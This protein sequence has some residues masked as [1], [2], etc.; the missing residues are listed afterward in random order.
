MSLLTNIV[1]YYKFDADNSNDALGTNNGTDTSMSY[2]TGKINDGAIFNG[3]TGKIDIGTNASLHPTTYTMT[4]W[5]KAGGSGTRPI[6]SL[7]GESS[8]CMR[9]DTGNTI[10][11]THVDVVNIGTSTG[12]VTNGTFAFICATY[13]S[14]TG[15]WQIYINGSL[16]NSGTNSQT[17]SFTHNGLIGEDGTVTH[18]FFSGTLDEV[19]LWSRVLTSG[20][21]TSLYNSGTGFQYPFTVTSTANFLAIL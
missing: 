11:L 9:V 17:Q 5:V 3:T 8:P 4:A 21:I 13:D 12:T 20:E 18:N 16:D 10:T 6:L 14:A 2:G 7:A 15:A 1:S 19:A